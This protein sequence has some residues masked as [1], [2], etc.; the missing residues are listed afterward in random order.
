MRG[1]RYLVR[2]RVRVKVRVRVRGAERVDVPR[3]PLCILREEAEDV[4]ALRP[5]DQPL[6]PLFLRGHRSHPLLVRR[7]G[8]V[9]VREG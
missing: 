7:L 9:R 2:V 4:D 6:E 3:R 1:L 8:R 5:L